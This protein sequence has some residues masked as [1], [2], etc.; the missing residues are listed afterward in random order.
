MKITRREALRGLLGGAAVLAAPSG[1]LLLEPEP[2][3]RYWQVG[4]DFGCRESTAVSVMGEVVDSDGNFKT[5]PEA[6]IQFGDGTSI[7]ASGLT[8]QTRPRFGKNLGHF[9]DVGPFKKVTLS[10]IRGMVEALRKNN[11]APH[12]DGFYHVHTQWHP[13]DLLHGFVDKT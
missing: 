9:D 8:L 1:L 6:T 11:A 13:E 10:E 3:R 5:Y 2:V 12:P 7:K 4:V